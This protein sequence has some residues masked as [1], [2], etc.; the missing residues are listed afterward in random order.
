MEVGVALSVKCMAFPCSSVLSP[1]AKGIHGA[2]QKPVVKLG[3]GGSLR[4]RSKPQLLLQ[5]RRLMKG[6]SVNRSKKVA[7]CVTRGPVQQQQLSPELSEENKDSV[8]KDEKLGLL[9][10]F[11]LK[12][13]RVQMAEEVGW[14][15]PT[16]GF[17][18]LL[19]VVK[20]LYV[21]TSKPEVE[22]A[23]LRVFIALFPGFVIKAYRN[24]ILPVGNGKPGAILMAYVTQATT[25]WLMGPSVVNQ[26]TLADG[27]SLQSGVLVER[28]KFLEGTQCAGVCTHMCKIPTQA[29]IKDVLGMSLQ[30]EPNF[31]DFSCQFNFGVEALPRDQDP[32]FQTPCLSICPTAAARAALRQQTE[33]D[34]CPQ[35]Q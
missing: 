15:S 12:A 5:P 19:E 10:Q 3:T 6:G 13:F 21:K 4:F 17:E 30:M 11:L 26:V 22:K 25:Y 33:T 28:C 27:S 9:D 23:V 29:F 18:G 7:G 31:N 20:H 8:S 1:E 2:M 35:V 34:Q 14:D 16:A 24:I 32:A